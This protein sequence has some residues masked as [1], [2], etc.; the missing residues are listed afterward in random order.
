MRK[1]RFD[2]GT[3]SDKLL[4]KSQKN[5]ALAAIKR[6]RLNP[7]QFRWEIEGSTHRS[8][9]YVHCIYY[10][11][12]RFYFKFDYENNPRGLRLSEFSPGEDRIK[13][14]EP[15][16]DWDKQL[17]DL[18]K[19]LG[20]LKREVNAPD[21]W[22][23]LGEYSPG[24]TF[25]GTTEISNVPFSY[26]EAENIIGSLDKLAAQIQKNFNLQGEQLSF[27]KREIDYLKDAAKRQGRK[28]WMHTSIGVMVGIAVNLA[29]SPEKAKLLWDMVRSCFAHILPLPAP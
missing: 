25:I 17:G 24:E 19:W 12:S 4:L 10:E 23:Q 27:V 22:E 2:D 9:W 8:D 18:I 13:Q 5:E 15:A 7:I 29:L 28:D 16:G 11:G 1:S 26:S 20:Y 6:F 3:A 14:F 21:P